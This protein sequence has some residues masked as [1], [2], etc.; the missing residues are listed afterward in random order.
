MRLVS[1]AEGSVLIKIFSDSNRH[2]PIP[3]PTQNFWVLGTVLVLG[4]SGFGSV[5]GLSVLGSFGF[6]F[7]TWVSILPS[8]YDI[9]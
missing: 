2:V 6:G 4:D 9:D 5:L 3:N 8:N 1:I 7:G